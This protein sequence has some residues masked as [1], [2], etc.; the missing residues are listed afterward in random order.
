MSLVVSLR[1]SDGIIVAADSL[2]TAQNLLEFVAQGIQID[3]PKCKGKI[4]EKEIK[5]PPIPIPFNASSYVQKLFSINKKF[6]VTSFGMGILNNKSIY[7]HARQF[8]KGNKSSLLKTKMESLISYFESQLITQFPDY[9]K[10]APD[11]WKPIGFHISGFENDDIGVTY[12][13]LIGKNNIIN[14]RDDIGCTIGGE[15]RIINKLWE[16]GKEDQKLQFK[17]GLFS[18]QD[19]IDFCEYLISATSSFQR[20]ANDVATVGGDID[21]ALLT[22]FHNF[23]WIKRKKLMETLE[24]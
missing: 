18:L 6:A 23:Q 8:E 10:K 15:P 17:Y 22:P 3:C 19:A 5:L 9:K 13:V 1:V 2:S 7:Y 11:E 14:K 21:I 16:I 12:E 4:S 20:F 24:K